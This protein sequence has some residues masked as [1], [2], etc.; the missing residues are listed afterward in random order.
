MTTLSNLNVLILG[1]IPSGTS[2]F[3]QEFLNRFPQAVIVNINSFDS[4]D[5]KL[6][7]LTPDLVLAGND[8]ENEPFTAALKY[9][10]KNYPK[11]PVIFFDASR[12]REE[13]PIN[14]SST[15]LVEPRADSDSFTHVQQIVKDTEPHIY[16]VREKIYKH[17]QANILSLQRSSTQRL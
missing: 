7:W 2:E 12:Q 17:N 5:Q 9:L 16:Q 6:N 15:F 11:L 8:F 14:G 10:R 13:L 1:N 3:R 4:I